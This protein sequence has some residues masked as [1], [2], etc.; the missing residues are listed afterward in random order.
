M[1]VAEAVVVVC[2]AGGASRGQARLCAVPLADCA[3]NVTRMKPYTCTRV[4]IH[5]FTAKF[6]YYRT[7]AANRVTRGYKWVPDISSY[8][9]L[10]KNNR[11]QLLLRG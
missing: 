6:Q 9:T 3:N 10:K 4:R 5:A 2:F 11:E 7:H 8:I 1:G